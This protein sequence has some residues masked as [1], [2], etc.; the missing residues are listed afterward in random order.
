MHPRWLWQQ[1][2]SEALQETDP[3]KMDHYILEASAAIEQRLLRPI[4]E[5]SEEFR[6]LVNLWFAVEALRRG[7][8]ITI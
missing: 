2:F 3:A 8:R 6:A 7:F 1:P 4:D 5:N